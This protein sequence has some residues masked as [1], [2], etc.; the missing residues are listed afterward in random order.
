M[1]MLEELLQ[2][3]SLE[4]SR[5]RGLKLLTVPINRTLLLAATF[6]Q[7]VLPG[8]IH[9]HFPGSEQISALIQHRVLQG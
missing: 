3:L 4:E 7:V 6:A 1:K 9:L 5:C 2:A 8:I